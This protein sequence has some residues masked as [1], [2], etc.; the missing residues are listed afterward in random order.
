MKSQIRLSREIKQK[1]CR[2]CGGL[3]VPGLSC[4]VKLSRDKT[5]RAMR[6][7]CHTCNT[8]RTVHLTGKQ[9]QNEAEGI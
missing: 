9:P 2:G 8:Q 6:L 4:D 5:M 1:L 7:V 3:L